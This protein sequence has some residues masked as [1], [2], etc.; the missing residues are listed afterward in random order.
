MFP[1]LYLAKLTIQ[2][3]MIKIQY[4]NPFGLPVT[5][6]LLRHAYVLMNLSFAT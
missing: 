4:P 3:V 5:F 6:S 2:V 1:L